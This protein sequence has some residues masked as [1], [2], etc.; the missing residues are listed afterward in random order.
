MVSSNLIENQIE[1]V[2][3]DYCPLL[4]EESFKVSFD[5][6]F[7]DQIQVNTVII[8]IDTFLHS[9]STKCLFMTTFMKIKT[10]TCQ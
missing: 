1:I 10:H 8:H 9:T 4:R 5:I 3:L 6:Q 7:L 2:L